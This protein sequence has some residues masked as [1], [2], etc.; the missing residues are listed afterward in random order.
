[1]LRWGLRDL[2]RTKLVGHTGGVA[3]FVSRVMLVPK[4]K[5]SASSFSTNAS[6]EGAFDSI[7]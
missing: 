1:M 5:I 3:G 4:G 2:S 6:K 7:L